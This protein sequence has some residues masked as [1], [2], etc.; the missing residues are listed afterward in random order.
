MAGQQTLTLLIG[1][2]IPVSQPFF[3]LS[4]LD[5]PFPLWPTAWRDIHLYIWYVMTTELQPL[6]S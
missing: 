6:F 5:F 1:V 3:F 2:R 4:L